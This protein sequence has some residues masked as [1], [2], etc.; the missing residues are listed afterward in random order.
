MAQGYGSEEDT[1]RCRK[2]STASVSDVELESLPPEAV[3]AH[4]QLLDTALSC[5]S[6]LLALSPPLSGLLKGIIL[7]NSHLLYLR[8]ISFIYA[9]MQAKHFGNQQLNKSLDEIFMF[10]TI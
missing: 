2:V 7:L 6:L 8:I 5:L 10:I 3:T 4:S 9:I 1:A